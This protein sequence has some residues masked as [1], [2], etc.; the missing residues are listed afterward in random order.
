MLINLSKHSVFSSMTNSLLRISAFIL[1]MFC[2]SGIKAQVVNEP[3]YKEVYNFLERLSNKGIIKFDDLILPLSRKTVYTK[4]TEAKEKLRKLTDL[5]KEELAFFLADYSL[6][7]DDTPV[8]TILRKDKL[9]RFRFFGYSGDLLKINV[10]PVAGIK[11]FSRENEFNFHRWNGI[12]FYGYLNSFLGFNFAFRDN[13][14]SGN[15]VDVK[16]SFTPQTGIIINNKTGNTIEYSEINV[17]LG[18]SWSW[19]GFSL[20]KDFLEWGYGRSGK[21]VLSSKAPSFPYLRL[22]I[23]PANWLRFNYIHAKLSSDVIDST[24]TYS[25]N[26]YE[27]RTTREK[28]FVSHTVSLLPFNGLSF[29]L[30]ESMIYS[31]RFE[32]VYLI[33]IMF[34]K[35][36]DH[37]LSKYDITQ[38]DNAQFFVNISSRNILKNTRLWITVFIDEI[39]F[40]KIF[41]EEQRKNQTGFTI[42]FETVDLPFENLTIGFEYTRINPFVYANFIQTQ[43]YE[44]HSYLLG[45][46]I[47]SNADIVYGSINYRFLRGLQSTLWGY[48]IR[49][50]SEGT[51]EQQY[52]LPQPGFLFGLKKY[53]SEIGLNLKYEL[54]HDLF[55]ETGFVYSWKKTEE[56]KNNFVINHF[57]NFS[58][59]LYYGL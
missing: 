29:S 24:K 30:G 26:L 33:P 40:T 22:D 56:S 36:A 6:E 35:A 16:K 12:R 7:S 46:W 17:N 59:S 50:G 25:A 48:F 49:K 44:N 51:A 43:T 57:E 19:G 10:E 8:K 5:E 52:S 3:L 41:D 20:G 1:F 15:T 13:G 39:S 31:D 21:I 53:Y 32:P 14:E 55:A 28:Y 37:Y 54:I 45:H 27:R 42:G 9:S 11:I 58:F 23:N 38:G 34:F 47:G 18:V 2:F 4:L